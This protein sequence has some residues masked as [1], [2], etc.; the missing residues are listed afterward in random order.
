MDASRAFEGRLPLPDADGI[1][2][3]GAKSLRWYPRLQCRQQRS[4]IADERL[5]PD[6]HDG[7]A[8]YYGGNDHRVRSGSNG[9]RI[10]RRSATIDAEENPAAVLF[11]RTIYVTRSQ[12][13]V[14]DAGFD[15]TA[16]K[17]PQIIAHLVD[18]QRF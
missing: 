4:R 5:S 9:G 11:A 15:R 6:H 8:A 10:P 1:R 14:P 13:H 2:R 16:G 18:V 7:V 3:S 17:S 12:K